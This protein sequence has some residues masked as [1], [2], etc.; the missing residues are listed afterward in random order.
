MM[1]NRVYYIGIRWEP[2]IPRVQSVEKALD[3][4]GDWV[5]FNESTWFLSTDHLS[6]ELYEALGKSLPSEATV[7]VIAVDPKDRFGWAPDWLWE[8]ID[9]QRSDPPKTA[10]AI[11]SAREPT[12]AIG[13]R[14]LTGKATAD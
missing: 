13:P 6:R 2:P 8:W 5:R 1:S 12:M 11:L 9:G 4:L 7:L 10:A 14:A 3:P